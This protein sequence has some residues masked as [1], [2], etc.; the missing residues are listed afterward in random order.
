MDIKKQNELI[1]IIVPIY[2]VEKYIDKCIES[3]VN[4]TYKNIEVLLIDDGSTDN[5]GNICKKWINKDNRIKYYHQNN[6]GVCSARNKGLNEANGKYIGFVDAD[7]WI[8]PT[9]YESL[10]SLLINYQCNLSIC[11]RIRIIEDKQITYP[12]TGIHYFE[13]GKVDMRML[14]CKYDLNICMNKLYKKEIFNELRFPTNMTYGEDLYIVP[15]ILSRAN[16]IVYTSNGLYYY[17]ERNNSASFSFN[18]LKALNDIEA[19]EKFLSYLKNNNVNYNTA[20][21][22]LFGAYTKG[23]FY[24][25]DKNK[26]NS[27]YKSFIKRNFFDCCIKFKCIL[28]LLSPNLY[29]YFKKYAKHSNSTYSI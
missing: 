17:L 1:S 25:K 7:D 6:S 22:W 28:F 18:E 16:K 19:K 8:S 14:A 4:Q 26:L 20:F 3:I 13:D 29:F 11:S 21:N 5:S 9:M 15:E 10:Y 23:Y 12:N 27:K 24:I 2:N